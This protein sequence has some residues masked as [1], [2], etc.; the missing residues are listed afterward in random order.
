[1]Y[2]FKT[3]ICIYINNMLFILWPGGVQHKFVHKKGEN[4]KNKT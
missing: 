1:M 2:I 4:Y 3:S